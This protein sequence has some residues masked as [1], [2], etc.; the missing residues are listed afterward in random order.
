MANPLQDF[1]RLH[2]EI[3]NRSSRDLRL[4]RR[5][6]LKFFDEMKTDQFEWPAKVRNVDEEVRFYLSR[7]I[8]RSAL[9]VYNEAVH[10]IQ[11][12]PEHKANYKELAKAPKNCGGFKVE[13][14]ILCDANHFEQMVTL[15]HVISVQAK[16]WRAGRRTYAF[17]HDESQVIPLYVLSKKTC[18]ASTMTTILGAAK[19]Q[20]KVPT[21]EELADSEDQAESSI[22]IKP[23]ESL[24]YV[25][26]PYFSGAT[27]LKANAF[28]T[29]IM[30]NSYRYAVECTNGDP[31]PL[32]C[33]ELKQQNNPKQ[34]PVKE[35]SA[36][37]N[38]L[39]LEKYSPKKTLV[40]TLNYEDWSDEGCRDDVVTSFKVKKYWK[41]LQETVRSREVE[42][43][44]NMM[45]NLFV[46]RA[47][48]FTSPTVNAFYAEKLFS[49][50]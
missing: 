36:G 23:L 50:D 41:V 5:N 31:F 18:I 8:D 42:E 15:D 20:Y 25:R 34:A 47:G 11:K 28:E 21:Y 9:R 49:E 32:A 4:A 13:K 27:M 33:V 10:L 39:F 29:G 43:L 38:A 7:V 3:P 35:L 16:D 2:T 24:E 19:G 26:Q 30:D 6:T 46:S 37:T 12:T 40:N 48:P 45:R 17:Y 22:F 14:S 44:D 1:S